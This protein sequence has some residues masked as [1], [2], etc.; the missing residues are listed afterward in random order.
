MNSI[1]LCG[2]Q[3]GDEGKGTFTDYLANV[4][5][6][7]SIVRY[8]GGSQASHTVITPTGIIH[9]FSQLGAG[10]F[11]EKCHT[12][13]TENMVVNL[14]NLLVEMEVFS[15][16]TGWSKESLIQR[17]H[18]HEDCFVVTPYHKLINKLRELWLGEE[19]RGTVGTGVSE[20]W[21]LQKEGKELHNRQLLGLQVKDIFPSEDSQ[22]KNAQ[23]WKKLEALQKHVTSFYQDHK[24]A[25]WQN[26]PKE[27]EE[28]LEQE[29]RFLLHPKAFLRI[30]SYYQ[31]TFQKAP[32]TQNLRHCLYRDSSKEIRKKCVNVIW[33]GAQGLLIDRT[34]GIRPNTTYLDTTNHFAFTIL[35]EEDNITKIGIAKAFTSRH[36]KGIFPT[37]EKEVSS[38]IVDSNQEVTFWNGKMRF[39]W[40]DAVLFRYAQ[41]INQVEQVYLAALDMLDEF[42]AIKVCNAYLYNGRKDERFEK[43]F[44]SFKT[45]NGN[46]VITDIKENGEDL[47]QYLAKCIPIYRTVAG[48]Q[49]KTT[50]AKS[51]K[52]LP[53]KCIEY[54][55]LLEKLIHLPITVVSVGPT[56]ENKITLKQ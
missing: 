17:L 48:W 14:D 29:I 20:V 43:L 34:Y 1:V 19:R 31:V 47:G 6:A 32:D 2:M 8:N 54:I 41:R 36:G 39:G 23:L 30:G 50:E 7:D 11:A 56:R 3:F 49:E 35:G 40:F 25:I 55:K 16:E 5:E 15:Q 21:L 24:I 10:M 38:K 28:K 4:T 37:E 51:E 9:K 33:E 45:A 46:F 53:T 26:A 52:Q 12:Y 18:I 44:Y 27:M 13:L 22:K 42:R